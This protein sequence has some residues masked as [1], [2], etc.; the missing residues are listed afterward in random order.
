MS[1]SRLFIIAIVINLIFIGA[2]L[3][4]S[5][6]RADEIALEI[7]LYR[8]LARN[9]PLTDNCWRLL[10]QAPAGQLAAYASA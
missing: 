3:G 8:R 10:A 2:Y 9:K 1:A 4:L 6:T 5:S 7:R